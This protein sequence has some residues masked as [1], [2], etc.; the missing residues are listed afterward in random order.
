MPTVIPTPETGRLGEAERVRLAELSWPDV[1]EPSVLVVPLGSCE[2]HGPHLPL[3]TDTRI[4]EALAA[5]LVDR[6]GDGMV[7][8]PTVGIGDHDAVL[9][10]VKSRVGELE[11]LQCCGELGGPLGHAGVELAVG[12]VELVMR[13]PAARVVVL[14]QRAGGE[15]GEQGE[16]E[17]ET[18]DELGDQGGSA[19]LRGAVL[20]EAPRRGAHFGDG[21]ADGILEAPAA[22][23]FDDGPSRLEAFGGP[24]VDQQFRHLEPLA[25]Q[26]REL[27]S[28]FGLARVGGCEPPQALE[29]PG[30]ERGC[31]YIGHKEDLVAGDGVAAAGR[32]R[33][34]SQRLH[35][36]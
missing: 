19:R 6:L 32:F 21:L 10:A 24:G 18:D 15:R 26:C 8:G 35:R 17:P 16:D 2:Q 25:D 4:A 22:A 23:R 1:P 12:L 11:T 3:D 28:V 31:A 27:L 30:Y 7:L 13:A 20:I 36:L 9:G 34:R 14:Y 29:L 33:V 5:A